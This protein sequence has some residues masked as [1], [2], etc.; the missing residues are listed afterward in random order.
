MFGEKL[1]TR[2]VLQAINYVENKWENKR[3]NHK[4]NIKVVVVKEGEREF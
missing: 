1:I 3:N 4:Y 2:L